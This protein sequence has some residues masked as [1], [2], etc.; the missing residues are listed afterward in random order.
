MDCET[1]K[2]KNIPTGSRVIVLIRQIKV[3]Y[4]QLSAVIL[5]KKQFV[6]RPEGPKTGIN[7]IIFVL[8]FAENCL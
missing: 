2:L 4:R 7:F 8:I 5:M 6:V 3:I 1:F